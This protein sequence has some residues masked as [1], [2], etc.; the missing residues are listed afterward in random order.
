MFPWFTLVRRWRLRFRELTYVARHIYIIRWSRP[1]AKDSLLFSSMLNRLALP[2]DL[3]ANFPEVTFLLF[4]L[5]QSKLVW[6][7]GHTCRP[8]RASTPLE[9]YCFGCRVIG[10]QQ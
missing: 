8:G 10:R 4:D 1:G 7:P 2:L 9:V 6:E 5:A 3:H